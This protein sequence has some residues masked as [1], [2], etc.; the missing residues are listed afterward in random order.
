VTPPSGRFLIQ[1]FLVPALIVAVAVFILLGFRYLV[2][3]TR[4]TESYLSA[5]DS[6][7]ADIRWRGAHDLAQVLKR[8]ESLELASDTRFALDLAE[9]LRRAL[10]ELRQ[11]EKA[12][13]ERV[14][15]L[16]AAQQDAAWRGLAAQRNHVLYLAACLG[17]FA[18]PVGVPLLS[19]MALEPDG[20][21]VKGSTLRRRRAVWALANLG[22]NFKRRYQGR[23][24]QPG[25]KVL[26]DAQK[27][28]MIAELTQ[29]AAGTGDRATWA[30]NTLAYLTPGQAVAASPPVVRVD[31]TLEQCAHADDPYLR[32]LVAL[33]LNF[34]DG[35]R[36]E[37]TLRELARDDGHGRRI[38]ITDND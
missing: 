27:Q 7:N 31:Q 26:S 14:A 19:D 24:T 11:A 4:T 6:P 15:P 8:P 3:G 10:D 20:P 21:D 22:E 30:R 17:D 16:P 35:D 25:E 5:L 38:E 18:V 23:T 13:A 9:R 33:A 34:W 2:S 29:E 1:L 28:A 12:T 36:V 37:P 32:S